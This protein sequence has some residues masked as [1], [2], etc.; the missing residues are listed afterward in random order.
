MSG[1][2]LR[3]DYDDE[4]WK[5]R[6]T[7]EQLLRTPATIIEVFGAIQLGLSL[8]GFVVALVAIVWGMIDPAAVD[9]E[10]MTWYEALAVLV[11]A[12]VLGLVPIIWN[13]TIIRGAGGMRACRNYRLAISAA[14]LS[15]LPLPPYYCLPISAPVAVWALVVLLRRDVRARFRAVAR[16]TMNPAPLEALN[17]RRTDPP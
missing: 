8:L 5:G 11:L 6:A 9:A 2:D 16:G 3:D 10:N 15:F 1:H 4:P 17:A 7:P 14:G 13:L 12:L